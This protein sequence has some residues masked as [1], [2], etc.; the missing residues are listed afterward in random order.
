[1]ARV[2][3]KLFNRT[4]FYC[5]DS[6]RWKIWEDQRVEPWYRQNI[7]IATKD[8]EKAGQEARLRPVIHPEF[9]YGGNYLTDRN[10]RFSSMTA[11]ESG[12]MTVQW[13]LQ[14]PFLGLGS[15]LARKIW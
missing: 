4:G 14:T 1:M 3:Q 6:L 13:Y 8:A 10:A 11:I 12:G 5:D 15:K 7:F 2:L 9:L